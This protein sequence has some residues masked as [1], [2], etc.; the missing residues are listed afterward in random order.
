MKEEMGRTISEALQK[1]QFLLRCILI[2][3]RFGQPTSFHIGARGE[4]SPFAR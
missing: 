1:R 3:F 2:L 4:E